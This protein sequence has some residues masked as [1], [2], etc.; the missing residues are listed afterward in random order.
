[1]MNIKWNYA[2]NLVSGFSELIEHYKPNEFN[3]P[4]RSTV[5]LL[6]YW[7]YPQDSLAEMSE[8]FA[9]NLDNVTSLDFEHEVPVQRGKGR[10]SCTDLMVTSGNVSVCIEA[11]FTEP[12]YE[13]VG[14]WLN[15]SEGTNRHQVLLGWLELLNT[16]TSRKLNVIDVLNLPYQ[17]IHRAA[18]ACQG[19][20][21]FLV[22]QLFYIASGKVET[23]FDD[24][25]S[26]VTLLGSD[27]SLSVVVAK[28]SI[29]PTSQWDELNK[30]WRAGERDLSKE[31]I[32]GLKDGNLMNIQ[33]ENV[34]AV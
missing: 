18:S 31:V 29:N 24:L 8:I 32:N 12:R 3:S 20:K 13:D 4:L 25:K 7:K 21:S 11:K 34:I 14:H 23:S 30:R 33:L 15:K 26:L 6:T 22:Y 17:L 19:R 10:A 1:M 28:C 2:G 27:T 16:C 9:F 5:P